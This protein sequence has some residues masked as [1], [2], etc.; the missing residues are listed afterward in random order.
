[1]EAKVHNTMIPCWSCGAQN[2]ACFDTL[3]ALNVLIQ[4]NIKSG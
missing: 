1:M 2:E 4:D 3:N